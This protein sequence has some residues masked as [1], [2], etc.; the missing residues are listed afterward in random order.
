MEEIKKE[1]LRANTTECRHF[2][3]V[4]SIFRLW[5]V[6]SLLGFFVFLLIFWIGIKFG[7]SR[8]CMRG[9]NEIPG[10]RKMIN[11]QQKDLVPPG[12]FQQQ[13]KGKQEEVNSQQPLQTTPQQNN[14]NTK[15]VEQSQ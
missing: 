1:V 2:E 6:R 14:Q 11:F 8:M 13:Q 4:C 15:P 3:C 9:L 5:W 12:D 10:Q 7:E